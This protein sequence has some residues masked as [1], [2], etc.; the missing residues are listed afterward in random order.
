MAE[1]HGRQVYLVTAA[2]LKT[3]LDDPD[4]RIVDTRNPAL[5][6]AGHIPG[7]VFVDVRNLDVTDTSPDG[8]GA[9]VARL[10]RAFS[11][12]GIREGQQVVF[13]EETSGEIATR[14]VWVLAYLGH[15]GACLL[16]GGLN[17]WCRAGY[18]IVAAPSKVTPSEFR[19]RPCPDLVATRQCVLERI[20]DPSVRFLDV[21]RV[22]EYT[23]VEVRANRGGRI[24]GAMHLEWVSNLEPGG[25][26]KSPADLAALYAGTQL[27]PGH[28][29]IAYCQGGYRSANTWLA[30]TLLGYPRVRNY[31]GGWEEWGNRAALPIENETRPAPR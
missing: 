23:G 29:I 25:C 14:G 5:F 16:D 6:E 21:R 4:V 12:A 27:Y 22:E 13:Y 10:E 31:V 26:Y 2:W 17:A 19:A 9:W 7:S 11:A 1:Q 15:N 28:E 20:G 3:H 30:L 24:P 18:P 8:L